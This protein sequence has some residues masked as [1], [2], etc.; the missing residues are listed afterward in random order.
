MVELAVLHPQDCLR[1]HLPRRKPN[2][3]SNKTSNRRKR[4]PEKNNN[5]N[6]NSN[7]FPAKKPVMGQVKILK[8]GEEL[9]TAMKNQVDENKAINL[10]VPKQKRIGDFYAGSAC[11][12]S[13]SP[14]SLPLPAFFTKKSVLG[15]NNRNA[16]TDLRRLLGLDLL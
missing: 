13:P 16:T 3:N 10:V 1:D 4:S 2:T 15:T 12:S 11:I 8:R 5:N 9:T 7:S 14:S 6:K